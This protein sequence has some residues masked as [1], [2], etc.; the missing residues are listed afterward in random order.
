MDPTIATILGAILGALLTG[1]VTYYFT[2]NLMRWQELN[3]AGATFRA[4]FTY[5]IRIL[6][7]YS[8]KPEHINEQTVLELLT[9]SIVKHE[10]ACIRFRPYLCETKQV[11]F[12]HA[13]QEYCHPQGGDPS[14]MP[15]PLFEYFIDKSNHDAVNLILSKIEKLLSFAKPV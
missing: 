6:Q 2:R 8:K 13:W 5:E 4:T 15:G 14:R 3:K 10:H 1:P 9:G 12:D 7:K 11:S